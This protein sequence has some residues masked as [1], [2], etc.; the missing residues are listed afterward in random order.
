M[1]TYEFNLDIS[2]PIIPNNDLFNCLL[3]F[4]GL[5][6]SGCYITSHI[7][8]FFIFAILTSITVHF[9]LYDFEYNPFDIGRVIY[10]LFFIV[11][12]IYAHYYYDI[13]THYNKLIIT[14][15]EEHQY[16][17]IKYIKNT[18]LFLSTI[19]F[20][21]WLYHTFLN[22]IKSTLFWYIIVRFSFLYTMCHIICYIANILFIFQIHRYQC[23]YFKTMLQTEQYTRE[24]CIDSFR[25]LKKH[26]RYSEQTVG[27]LLNLG[28]ICT[29]FKFPIDIIEFIY[30]KD[31]IILLTFI[32]NTS[33]F[34]CGLLVSAKINDV[35][36]MFLTKLYKNKH[37][38]KNYDELQYYITFFAH[39]KIYFRVLHTAPTSETISKLFLI[40]MNLIGSFIMTLLDKQ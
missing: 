30:E 7:Y 23:R 20:G 39:N 9:V 16:I 33:C 13:Y 31:I 37:I 10:Y 28:M 24:Q 25:T 14:L 26:I 22:K 1:N 21:Y 35:N 8:P 4:S 15:K 5:N 29:L 34:L 17:V 2:S 32:I 3:R 27:T 40:I 12:F 11:F 19:S 38:R 18:T 36:G 6:S